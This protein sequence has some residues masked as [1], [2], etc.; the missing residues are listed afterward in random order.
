MSTFRAKR[1]GRSPGHPPRFVFLD[2]VAA[3]LLALLFLACSSFY[4]AA[5]I[6]SSQS[7]TEQLAQ[8]AVKA[9]YEAYL[10]VWKDKDYTALNNL[11]SDDYQ[12][13]NFQG[14]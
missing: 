11:L 10:R 9:T 13:V 3:L 2:P 7:G 12:A 8:G 14:T 6:G 1:V 4:V 5:Q